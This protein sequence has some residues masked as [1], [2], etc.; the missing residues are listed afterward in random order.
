MSVATQSSPPSIVHPLQCV[1]SERALRGRTNQ[2]VR[3]V[4]APP[5]E[6]TPSFRRRFLPSALHNRPSNLHR[7]VARAPIYIVMMFFAFQVR[8]WGRQRPKKEGKPTAG[9]EPATVRFLAVP[10]GKCLKVGSSR[11]TELGGLCVR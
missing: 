7:C 9:V 3:T 8:W 4:T 6:I 1:A 5:L 11:P 2:Q 10:R